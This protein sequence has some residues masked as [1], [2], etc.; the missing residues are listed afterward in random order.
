[1]TNSVQI[2]D[3]LEKLS[4]IRIILKWAKSLALQG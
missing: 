4:N 1:M 3:I 2:R